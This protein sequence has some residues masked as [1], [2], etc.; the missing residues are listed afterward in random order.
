MEKRENDNYTLLDS[1]K[2]YKTNRGRN[3]ENKNEKPQRKHE[4]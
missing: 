2:I 3:L 1:E 4:A